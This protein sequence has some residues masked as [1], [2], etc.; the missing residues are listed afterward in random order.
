MLDV[1]SY[2]NW[3]RMGHPR[4]AASIECGSIRPKRCWLAGRSFSSLSEWEKSAFALWR[5]GGQPSSQIHKSDSGGR[6][7]S[8]EAKAGGPCTKS[9]E[10]LLK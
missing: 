5:Y 7:T 2:N 10:L 9:P 6:K 4:T 3:R 1:A 8:T